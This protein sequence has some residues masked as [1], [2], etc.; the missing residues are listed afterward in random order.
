MGIDPISLSIAAAAGSGLLAGGTAFLQ[1]DYQSE[2]AKNN[3]AVAKQ[4]AIMASARAGIQ[5]QENDLQTK[6]LLGEQVAAQAASGVSLSGRSQFLT[7]QTARLLGRRDTENILAAGS[8]ERS[9][10][11]TQARQ[12]K[13]ESKMANVSKWLGAAGGVLD[14]ATGAASAKMA[15]AKLPTSLVG[16]ATSVAKPI[17]KP[18]TLNPLARRK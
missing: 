11:L 3:A 2:V 10:F 14:A 6:A 13:A 12:F 16:G 15:G 5:A 9:N 4:N 18:A 17:P 8:A 1:G 7:R